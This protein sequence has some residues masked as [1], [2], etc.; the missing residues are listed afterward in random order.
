MSPYMPTLDEHKG[1]VIEQ[2]MKE[3]YGEEAA[4]I[5]SSFTVLKKCRGKFEGLLF[6]MLFIR[7][8]IPSLN[9]Q[10]DSIRAELS[11][12]LMKHALSDVSKLD[13]TLEIT[14]FALDIPTRKSKNKGSFN[15]IA[16]TLQKPYEYK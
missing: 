14:K 6:E 7:D 8:I 11:T 16:E 5:E 15:S 2:H 1:S 10:S 4:T 12:E 13:V 9:K 3:S